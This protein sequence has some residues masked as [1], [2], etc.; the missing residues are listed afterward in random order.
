[1]FLHFPVAVETIST[2]E[3]SETAGM[4]R[5]CVTYT[6]LP[7][8]S[9][10]TGHYHPALSSRWQPHTERSH[11]NK[12]LCDCYELRAPITE[13][14]FCSEAPFP[15][16]MQSSMKVYAYICVSLLYTI[17]LLPHTPSVFWCSVCSVP[18]LLSL[19]H[20]VTLMYKLTCTPVNRLLRHSLRSDIALLP[21][22]DKC[23]RALSLC[24]C[25]LQE[26]EL[27]LHGNHTF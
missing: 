27:C 18:L 17:G 19:S 14:L 10:P 25:A 6:L 7:L 24:L 9:V 15:L 16:S 2:M 26:I 23:G 22:W 11:I 20:S 21:W 1:M 5:V 8:T 4:Y 12:A 13:I 3:V